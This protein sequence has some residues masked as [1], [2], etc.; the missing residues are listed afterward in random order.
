MKLVK[1]LLLGSP[2]AIVALSGAYAAD[3][4]VT[5]A[6]PVAY[7]KICDAYGAGFFY[8]PGT[9]TCLKVGG[10]IRAQ[11]EYTPRRGELNYTVAN[12]KATTVNGV[13]TYAAPTGYTA[14]NGTTAA[15]GAFLAVPVNSGAEDSL[16]WLARGRVDM[17]A[18]TASPW[19]TVRAVLGLRLQVGSGQF[20]GTAT[21]L[22][23]G[24]TIPAQSAWAE[25]AYVQF[26]GFTAG[27]AG[28]N[29]AFMPPF[30]WTGQ[31]YW[32]GY[33][34]GMKQ[35]AYTATFGGGFSATIA[36]EDKAD[37]SY[38]NANPL[39]AP[40]II[41]GSVPT[42][43]YAFGTG[44]SGVLV[45]PNDYPNVVGNLRVDQAWGSAQVMATVGQNRFFDNTAAVQQTFARIGWAVGA[46]LKLN[47]PMLAAGD[48]LWL[49]AAY[50]EGMLDQ[51]EGNSTSSN[52]A[53]SSQNLRG[54]YRYDQNMWTN[55]VDTGL[56][57][58]WSAGGLFV[59]YWT[60]TLRSVFAASYINLRLPSFVTGADWT[61]GGLSNGHA[62]DVSGS[63]IWAPVT[64]FDIGLELA[65]RKLDQSINCETTGRFGN[66]CALFAT[67]NR[68][69][70]AVS[71]SALNTRLRIQ[72]TF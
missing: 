11:Y 5:K 35:L 43:P 30:T 39:V 15:G 53:D 71:P 4:P 40:G 13:T 12:V 33:P 70:A 8:I 36:L 1:S 25:A 50:A 45:Y 69:G 67:T 2:A 55:G 42:G 41:F 38:Q 52:N 17:D 26:A 57:K 6:A 31:H 24:A 49:T 21:G 46:G 9:D 63:I 48:Q 32:A 54:V 20:Q 37:F 16:G 34:V 58:G 28:E 68:Y 44:N 61:Q 14:V 59:H 29:F 27:R 64:N 62:Y 19:G 51:L 65:Y 10:Y 60:P 22:A 72:R 56:T 66:T 18:R 7:V 23:Y 3:L 47:L